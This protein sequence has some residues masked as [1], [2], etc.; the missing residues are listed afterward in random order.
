MIIYHLIH[1]QMNFKLFVLSLV[2]V[3]FM[4]TPAFAKGKNDGQ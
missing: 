2:A 1:N 3:L 4:A